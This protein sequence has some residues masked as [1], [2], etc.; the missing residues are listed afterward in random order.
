MSSRKLWLLATVL[1]V[2][3]M[4]CFEAFRGLVLGGNSH[5]L[6]NHLIAATVQVAGVL[7]F[8]SVVF[9]ILDRSQRKIVAQNLELAALSAVATAVAKA[10]DLGDG[11]KRSF[12]RVLEASRADAIEVVVWD[13]HLQRMVPWIHRATVQEWASELAELAAVPTAPGQPPEAYYPLFLADVRDDPRF[14]GQ[15]AAQGRFRSFASIPLRVKD[16]TLGLL[17]VA[18]RGLGVLGPTA[19]P[20]LASV[21][22]QVAVALENR[23]LF[24]EVQ[25]RERE[26]RALYGIA[27]EVLSSLDLDRVLELIVEHTRSLLGAEAVGLC[28]VD[29][30]S[31]RFCLARASGPAEAFRRE[32]AAAP[33]GPEDAAGSPA[34]PP[35]G[36]GPAKPCCDARSA[37]F[38]SHISAPLRA[39]NVLIGEL[40]VGSSTSR[41]LTEREHEL[42]TT[43]ANQAALAISNARLYA[44]AQSLAILEERDRIAREMHDSLAQVLG[45]LTLRARTIRARLRP[46]GVE[47]CR[48]DLEEMAKVA[49]EAYV[50][51]REAILGLRE[52]IGH[53]DGL[54]GAL[55]Q[56]VQKFSRQS[57]IATKLVIQG[58]K[59]PRFPTDVEVQLIRIIQ[60]ALT[61]VRKHSGA[62]HAWVRF[63]LEGET[64]RICIQDDGR[65]FDQVRVPGSLAGG[66]GMQMMNER[67]ERVG[68][69]LEVDSTRGKGT[70]VTVRVPVER[71]VVANGTH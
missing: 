2:S 14:V 7:V 20:L 17:N 69:A 66:F 27:T 65:G 25:Q 30:R 55:A 10:R 57:G 47:T 45:Y 37:Y 26:A 31:G 12:G 53:G 36:A 70:R 3:L 68:G 38:Q 62:R 13:D 21:A 67:A 56:Y 63:N 32:P 64:G 16:H 60:E 5:T 49:D 71:P 33:D 61:N 4:L 15:P 9:A 48:E 52:S 28:L 6:E 39:G 8:S 54:A 41:E 34:A 23:N 1:P 29:E 58:D 51:V 19:Q 24:E 35:A 40:C 50:D 22:R 11:L 18:A 44:R 42:L 59:P 43:L 46:D